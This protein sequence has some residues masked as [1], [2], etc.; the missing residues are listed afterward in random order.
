MVVL[1]QLLS[2]ED[3]EVMGD[4]QAVEIV[5][6]VFAVE[7]VRH[8]LRVELNAKNRCLHGFDAGH[9]CAAR[10]QIVRRGEAAKCRSE[11]WKFYEGSWRG[12]RRDG[13]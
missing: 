3:G 11:L 4:F 7:L 8:L 12:H 9:K 2:Q 1:Q 6:D 10:G 13:S 5:G